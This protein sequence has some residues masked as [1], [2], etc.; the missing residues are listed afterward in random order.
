ML[1]LAAL[2]RHWSPVAGRCRLRLFFH[3]VFGVWFVRRDHLL[4]QFVRHIIVVRKFHRVTR[5]SLRHRRQV[6]RVRQHLRQ[7]HLPFHDHVVPAH[8]ASFNPAAPRAQISHQVARVLVRRVHFHVHDR[9]QQRRPRLLHRFLERQRGTR[10]PPYP[11]FPF[12]RTVS[13]SSVSLR[14]KYRPRIRCPSRAPAVRT[15]PGTRQTARARRTV[16][17]VSLPRPPSPGSSPGTAPSA[18]SASGPRD[19][20]CAASPPPL[21]CAAAPIP[22][23]RTLSSADLAK[24]VAPGPPP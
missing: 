13:S 21:R 11:E 3:Q 18:A 5:P 15:S 16:S 24:T 23:A 9:F 17:C 1:P 12:P 19:T 4:R 6:R 14:R 10:A 2:F 20:A 7:R 8:F 22:P